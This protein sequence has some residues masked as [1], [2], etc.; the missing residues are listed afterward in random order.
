MLALL[1]PLAG[2]W[3]SRRDPLFVHAAFPWSAIA[4][5]IAGVRYGFGAG[6]GCAA[7]VVFTMLGAWQH[8]LPL[9][10]PA[11]DFPMQLSVGLLIVG[12]VA[13]EF[14]DLWKRRLQGL[15][16][17][18]EQLRRRFDGFARTYQALRLSHDLLESRVA[19]ATTTVREGLRALARRGFPR[20][21]AAA[22]AARILDIF[23]T[24]CDA[25]VAAVY[26]CG[27]DGE[28]PIGAVG[29]P[30]RAGAAA[31]PPADPR[32][33]APQ[34]GR[35][36]HA[37]GSD[38]VGAAKGRRRRARPPARR[39]SGASDLLIA[40]PFID[41]DDRVRG[42]LV[43]GDM[44]FMAFGAETLRRIAV[45][46]GPH[47]RS[48]RHRA[49]RARRRAGGGGG[50]HARAAARA[51]RPARAR[52]AGRRGAVRGRG[53]RRR[54]AGVVPV[55][56]AAHHRSRAGAARRRAAAPRSPCSCR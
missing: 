42:L 33:A 20:A 46:R 19:G 24:H 22:T 55:R 18:Q 51:A 31:R 56:R 9:P 21:D 38:G 48:A 25:R 5:L 44:P 11:E 43:V 30:G 36:R 37:A 29:E 52:A 13:G 26:L 2:A 4:P 32:G 41:L 7:L 16:T 1:V 39:R 40:A 34:G 3:V 27:D 28:L 53:A 35:Q 45:L 10:F 54:R 12:M 47:R 6:F 15:E 8:V 14:S 17:E 50:V 49:R 23:A